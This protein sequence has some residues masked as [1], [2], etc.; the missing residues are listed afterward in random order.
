MHQW[1]QARRSLQGKWRSGAKETM[2]PLGLPEGSSKVDE[3][4]WHMARGGTAAAARAA[5]GTSRKE[6]FALRNGGAKGNI[7]TAVGDATLMPLR[8][9]WWRAWRNVS[10][11]AAASSGEMYEHLQSSGGGGREATSPRGTVKSIA[12]PTLCHSPPFIWNVQTTR[13]KSVLGYGRTGRMAKFGDGSA[14]I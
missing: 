4:A 14:T 6:N 11:A 10:H 8:R 3:F 12:P 7:N 1:C 5:R 2:Q 13:M 9:S